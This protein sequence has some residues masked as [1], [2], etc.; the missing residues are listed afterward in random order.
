MH[1]VHSQQTERRAPAAGPHT[2]PQSA[3]T[4]VE[5]LEVDLGRLQQDAEDVVCIEEPLELAEVDPIDT[6]R[7]SDKCA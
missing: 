6:Q 4:Q 5:S 3:E 7:A 1:H 2:R